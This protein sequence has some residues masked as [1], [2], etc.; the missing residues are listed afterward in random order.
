VQA[1]KSGDRAMYGHDTD[2]QDILS[3]KVAVPRSARELISELDGSS[4]VATNRN[5]E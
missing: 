1:D 3:G 5:H 2:R 4:K